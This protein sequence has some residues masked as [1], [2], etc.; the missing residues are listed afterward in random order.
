M[1]N[2]KVLKPFKV[3]T[4]YQSCR[5]VSLFLGMWKVFI[6]I[7]EEKPQKNAVTGGTPKDNEE[8]AAQQLGEKQR[9][10]EVKEANQV[11]VFKEGMDRGWK[12]YQEAKCDIS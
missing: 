4:G 10:N 1:I 8:R 6:L 3:F 9:K 5:T 7:R 11:K 2:E 12:C